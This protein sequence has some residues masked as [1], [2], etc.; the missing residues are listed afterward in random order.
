[1]KKAFILN[2][3]VFTVVFISLLSCKTTEQVDTDTTSPVWGLLQRGDPKARSYFLG[4]IDVNAID[5]DGKTPLHYAAE[6]RDFQLAGFLLAIGAKPNA[7]DFDGQTPLGISI[8]NMD[9]LVAEVLAKGGADIH[10]E[11][12]ENTTAAIEALKINFL[13]KSLLTAET[14]KSSDKSGKNVLHIAS[15]SGNVQAV[16][17]IISMMP[18]SAVLIN[19]RDNAGKNAL[20]YSL[21]KPESRNHIEIAEQLILAGGYSENAVFNY[22]GPA[23]RSA[24]YNIRR[25]EGLAPIHYA[26]IDEHTGMISF[27]IDKKIDINI[28]SNSGATAL[29]EAVRKGN[30]NI[31]A[32]LLENGADVNVRD[33]KGNSPLHT[34]IP[35]S[36]HREV[37]TMMLEKGADPNLRDEYGDIP[38]HVAITLNRSA[39][40][41]QALLSGGSDVHIRNIEGKTPLYIA[42]QE[43]RIALIP[44]L[45]S[46]GSEIFAA[47]NSGV[48]P[49]DVAARANDSTFN[50]LITQ[51]TV[52]QRD[53]AGNTMLHA[54][55]RN[56]TNPQQ[57][58]RILDQRA[59]VDARNRDGDTAL[60]FAV[61][62]NQRENGEFL[63]TRGA[64][65]FSINSAGLSP[66]NIALSSNPIRDWIINPQ[67][68]IAKD[69]LG[70][71]I[72]H[73]AAEW[74]LVNAIP[75]IL[76]AGLSIETQNATGQT[77]LFMAIRTDS[78]STIRVLVENSAN[79]NARDSQGNSA[80]HAAIRWNALNSAAYLISSGIDIN[81]YSLNGNTPL[82]DAVAFGMSDIETLL[83]T[84]GANLDV[85]NVDGNTPFMEAV[86]GAQLGSIEK[87][88]R[89]GSDPSARNIRGDTPLHIAVGMENIELTNILLR[90][91]A[92]I[93]ARNTRN[94]TP[95]HVSLSVSPRMVSALLSGGRINN[96]DD[97]GNSALHIAVQE[98]A[99]GDIIRAI[100]AQG[101]RLNTVDSNGKTPL[102]ISV[103]L[104]LWQTVKLIADAGADPFVNAVDNKTVGEIAF[105]KGEDCIRA[106]FSGRAI[107]AKDSSGN[108]VLHVGARFGN[109]VMLNF[110]LEL[111]ANRTIRNIASESPYDIA[112]RWHKGENANVLAY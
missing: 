38:L 86:K 77:P 91:G 53:S 55:V 75:S 106:V 47:D 60:H 48:A 90:M 52:N 108:T 21:E 30:I 17:D 94:I 29:H 14:I 4:E 42:V 49:F 41:I 67:T 19:Q 72:L 40:V 74:N 7:V 54:A 50:L 59:P 36:V 109:P 85:R 71:T 79:L 27:L 2:F 51:E 6:T 78:P 101:A 80:L 64:N 105:I 3:C 23:V 24:N 43:R 83:I 16:S 112:V 102:R 82:H 45:I 104:E 39:E 95:F 107:N 1:M 92:S 110:L 68:I 46:Y 32:T 18:S 34:G 44:I 20:D 33:A 22:F 35:S 81:S 69:G 5:K 100:I 103:D 97:S 99:S 26:V 66:L 70:N 25:T 98:R 73:Y 13:F 84:S 65:L 89:N 28:K 58:S 63:I 31:I 93:H 11:I 87:L 57:I 56:R 96:N 37:V 111:G 76:R 8:N 62:M 10:F 15:L 88:A 9:S 12:P 61:R